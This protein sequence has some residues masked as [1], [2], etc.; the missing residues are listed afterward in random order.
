MTTV[1]TYLPSEITERE[2]RAVCKL[3]WQTWTWKDSLE[4]AFA[5]FKSNTLESARKG[6]G[7]QRFIVWEGD[8]V[9]AHAAIFSREV[10]TKHG[11]LRL[12]ALTGVCAHADYRGHRLG[13]RVV[14]AAFDLVDQGEFSVILWQTTVPKFYEKLGARIVDNTWV[15]SH[16]A[17]N[18]K[19]DPWPDE[20][21]MIYPADYAWPDGQIDLNGPV[22]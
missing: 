3:V 6:E 22:Y 7:R 13:S 10:H 18:P 20:L 21:K 2:L 17:E 12:G 9:V 19:A 1:H 4:E 8:Q 5:E 14:R 16:N 11:T 15:N